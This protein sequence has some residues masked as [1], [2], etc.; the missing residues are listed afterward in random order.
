M[1]R[2]HLLFPFL[3]IGAM[4]ML[5]WVPFQDLFPGVTEETGLLLKRLI[6]G[7]L[8][9]LFG[10]WL[11]ARFQLTRQNYL[12]VRTVQNVKTLLP[13]LLLFIAYMLL[14]RRSFQNAEVG[15]GFFLFILLTVF[16][17]TS[18]EELIFRAV[19]QSW[20]IKKAILP[21]KASCMP[22]SCFHWCMP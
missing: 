18:S 20:L 6:N 9:C 2:K 16:I 4:T 14:T 11:I 7:A 15:A 10:F 17:K 12:H 8:V 13:A 22:V 3:V 19:L 21:G 5:I 1:N